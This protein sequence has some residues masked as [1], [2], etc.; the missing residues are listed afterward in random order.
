MCGIN[1][2]YSKSK[3]KFNNI[4]EKMNYAISHRGPDSNGSWSDQKSGIVLGHQRLSII[5]LSVAGSQPMQSNSGRFIITYNGEI[6]NHIEIRKELE[7]SRYNL[8]WQGTSDTE[9]LLEAIDFWG[10][11]KALMKIE[12]MFSF[13]LWDKKNSS[14]TLVRDRMGE[15]P[16]Y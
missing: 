2:F 14:L 4:I 6:Y 11:E 8:N 9:T 15:K 3:S 1:G 12:G 5:D 7:L 13:G 10:I 16:L